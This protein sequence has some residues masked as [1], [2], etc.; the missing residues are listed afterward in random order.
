MGGEGK[1]VCARL[2]GR[3]GTSRIRENWDSE[4]G[5]KKERKVKAKPRS[6]YLKQLDPL[7]SDA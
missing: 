2:T 1:R 7:K 6:P 5:E 4:E 3:K